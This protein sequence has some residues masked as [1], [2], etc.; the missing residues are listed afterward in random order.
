[1]AISV[2]LDDEFVINARVYAQTED[3]SLPKQIEHWAKIGKIMIENPDLPYEFVR[4]TLISTAEVKEG[5][6]THYV[7]R[8]ERNR[9][10]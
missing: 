6:K 5:L 2:R 3:R 1:M 4:E 7:R 10:L 8:T 9:S